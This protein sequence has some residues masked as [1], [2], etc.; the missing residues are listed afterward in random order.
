MAKSDDKIRIRILNPLP[1][2]VIDRDIMYACFASLQ[3][4]NYLVQRRSSC[5]GAKKGQSLYQ[6]EH[7]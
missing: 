6:N 1:A 5:R 7:Q 2:V 3:G 4:C